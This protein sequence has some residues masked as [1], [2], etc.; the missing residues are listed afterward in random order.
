MAGQ[1]LNEVSLD[2]KERERYMSHLK[3]LNDMYSSR[4]YMHKKGREEGRKKGR[5]E[6]TYTRS[7]C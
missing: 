4:D 7:G 1:I 3:W 6:G 2:E 5:E